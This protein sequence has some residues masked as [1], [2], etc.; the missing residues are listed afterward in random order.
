MDMWIIAKENQF[1][2]LRTEKKCSKGW[3]TW[4]E[5]IDTTEDEN[6]YCT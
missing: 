6:Y 3:K 1:E 4:E 5:I 2:N